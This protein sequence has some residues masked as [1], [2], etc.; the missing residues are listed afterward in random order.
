MVWDVAREGS[1]AMTN[2]SRTT[3]SDS[4]TRVRWVLGTGS[5]ATLASSALD[6]HIF[7]WK[8]SPQLSSYQVLERSAQQNTM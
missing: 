8:V 6:G 1:E 5:S 3:H 7:L 4:V 2:T